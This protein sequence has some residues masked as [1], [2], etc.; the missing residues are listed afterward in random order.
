MK[1][2]IVLLG[3]LL[4]MA[5]S[6]NEERLTVSKYEDLRADHIGCL[7]AEGFST[8][9]M[10]FVRDIITLEYDMLI[11][12]ADATR[13]MNEVSES[14]KLNQRKHTYTL[15]EATVTT[16]KVKFSPTFAADA[17]WVNAAHE[18]MTYLNNV[19]GV[20]AHFTEVS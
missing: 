4:T 3:L 15:D 19:P 1:T 13:W 11:S 14:G 17:D 12:L 6:C 18:A 5:F 10:D 2:S 20:S 8:N 7:E 9:G 16:I